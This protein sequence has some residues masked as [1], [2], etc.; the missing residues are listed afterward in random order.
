M[1]D[2]LS[3]PDLPRATIGAI[4]QAGT[5]IVCGWRLIR[6][7]KPLWFGMAGLYLVFASLLKHIPFLGDLVIILFT[8][9]LLAG[10]VWGRAHEHHAA[11]PHGGGPAPSWSEAWLVQP[12]RELSLIFHRKDKVFPAVWLGIIAL[13]LVVLVRIAGE[14]LIG[15]SVVSGLKATRMEVPQI[16]TALGMLVVAGLYLVL[17][18]GLI[19]SIPLTILASLQPLTA[20]SE[21]FAL[22]R[23]NAPALLTLAAPFFAIYLLIVAGF[24]ISPSWGYLLTAT[25][26]WLAVPAL[27]ASVYCSYL[28]LHSPHH[29][30]APP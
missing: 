20:V 16:T 18:M 19:Y 17:V 4:V 11:T 27:V 13:G 26:G 22:C 6:K 2:P 30:A 5:W 25:A 10:V 15:G 28:T 29:C 1:N 9:M 8:P 3:T 7:H 21:S 24:A 14:L 23:S 12:A